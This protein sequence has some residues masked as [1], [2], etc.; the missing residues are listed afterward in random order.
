M[1]SAAPQLRGFLATALKRQC[2]IAGV[3]SL[4][5]VVATKVLLKDARLKKYEEFYKHYDADKDFERM[6]DAGVFR[7]V[8][9]LK[10]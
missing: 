8:K 6:R 5:A 4:V 3:I 7:C 10:K 1:A 9:P 2:I